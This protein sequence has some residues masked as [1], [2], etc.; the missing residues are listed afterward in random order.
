M[1]GF[2]TAEKKG[3]DSNEFSWL[4]TAMGGSDEGFSPKAPAA[5]RGR[6]AGPFALFR[7]ENN[8][9]QERGRNCHIESD[10]VLH[11]ATESVGVL[12]ARH[13]QFDPTIALELLNRLREPVF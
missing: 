13:G 11:E 9:H 2:R 10:A 3:V 12:F 6:G 5:G 8:D 4:L 7:S 1:F